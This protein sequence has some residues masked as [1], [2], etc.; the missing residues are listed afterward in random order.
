MPLPPTVDQMKL[1]HYWLDWG[2]SKTIVTKHL[3]DICPGESHQA[4]C[5]LSWQ[6]KLSHSG[7][8]AHNLSAF[9]ESG[10]DKGF[11]VSLSPDP[12]RPLAQPS[13][14]HWRHFRA[15]A[16]HRSRL[17]PPFPGCLGSLKS[18]HPWRLDIE[19]LILIGPS[20]FYLLLPD[21]FAKYK[22]TVTFLPVSL[23]VV[24]MFLSSA[25]APNFRDPRRSALGV[26]GFTLG[27]KKT[28]V[29]IF[30]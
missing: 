7:L 11:E 28:F 23:L 12:W 4:V 22:I 10:A 9:F 15:A 6:G 18:Q 26:D 24:T 3:R 16:I 2:S 19:K 14:G 27:L 20:G 30:G 17:P 1:Q 21:F 5:E 29:V 13:E 8:L 25:I